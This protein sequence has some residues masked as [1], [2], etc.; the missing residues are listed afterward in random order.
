MRDSSSPLGDL[1]LAARSSRRVPAI[2][3]ILDIP[4]IRVVPAIPAIAAILDIPNI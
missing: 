4:D 3:A 2:A 1:L